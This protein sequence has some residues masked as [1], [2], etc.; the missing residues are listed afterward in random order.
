MNQKE[1]KELIDFLIER[2]ISEFELQRGDEKVRIKRGAATS[3]APVA[4]FVAAFSPPP[5]TP[6]PVAYVPASPSSPSP[7]KEV[8]AVGEDLHIVKSPIV[9]TFYEAPAPGAPPF[10]K[11]GDVV[12]TGQVLCIIEAMKL[13]NEIE[14]DIAGEIV[15]KLVANNQA[16][17]YGQPLFAV[18]PRK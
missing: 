8:T 17:E 16:V 18:R 11:I 12:E 3:A 1:L 15:Q 14:T 13:M 9:G 7:P 5:Q 2:D 10:V 6:P 4:P